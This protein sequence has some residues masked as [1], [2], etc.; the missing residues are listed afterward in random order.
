M[1]LSEQ[2]VVVCRV[3]LV[4]AGGVER[5]GAG[6]MGRPRPWKIILVNPVMEFGL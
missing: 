5:S 3:G 1:A 2:T 4:T 6:K